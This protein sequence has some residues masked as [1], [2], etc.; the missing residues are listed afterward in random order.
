MIGESETTPHHRLFESFEI[1]ACRRS[2]KAF[3]WIVASLMMGLVGCGSSQLQGRV[4]AGPMPSIE[5]VAADDPR[6]TP[7]FGEPDINASL[8]VVLDPHRLNAIRKEPTTSQSNG[9]FSV[10]V[11]ETAG[12]LQTYRIR[13]MVSASGYGSAT[14]D[15][16]WPGSG[17]R[18]LVTL[19]PVGGGSEGFQAPNTRTRAEPG[20]LGHREPTLDELMQQARDLEAEL[21]P[22]R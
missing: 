4:I 6:L 21:A 14:E 5:I 3:A 18:I 8:R 11:P 20:S 12:G 2:P 10:A 22:Q 17:Q 15:L 9:V 19:P 16:T 1:D 7:Q 13:L